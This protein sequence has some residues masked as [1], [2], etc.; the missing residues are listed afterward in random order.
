MYRGLDDGKN[1][2]P[3]TLF[4]FH[5]HAPAP[6][7]TWIGKIEPR[8]CHLPPNASL[9]SH[10]PPAAAHKPCRVTHHW[11]GRP[12]PHHWLHPNQVEWAP[13]P[14][15]ARVCRPMPARV[16]RRKEPGPQ[17]P[18]SPLRPPPPVVGPLPLAGRCH[19]FKFNLNMTKF[20]WNL[21]MLEWNLLN[22]RFNLSKND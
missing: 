20:G 10:P 1:S 13:T 2:V 16:C 15:S 18:R 19:F 7:R 12:P 14:T 4:P 17:T 5:A 11:V 9:R 6:L 21:I 22:L 8:R 3:G